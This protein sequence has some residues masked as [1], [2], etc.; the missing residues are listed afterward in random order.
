M[1]KCVGQF[2]CNAPVQ[3]TT[4]ALVVDEDNGGSMLSMQ[5][6]EHLFS[7]VKLAHTSKWSGVSL[8]EA[9]GLILV[10]FEA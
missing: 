10:S 4:N 8:G 9:Q 7:P 5:S 3:N 6:V 2:R 1:S